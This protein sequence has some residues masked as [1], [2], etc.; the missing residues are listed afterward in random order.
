MG[1]LFRHT[2]KIYR[3]I[4]IVI[5]IIIVVVVVRRRR[6]RH[7]HRH[8]HPDPH[9]HH[10]PSSLAFGV[11]PIL[12]HVSKPSHPPRKYIEPIFHVLPV[13]KPESGL[14]LSV[15]ILCQGC[16]QHPKNNML[17]LQTLDKIGGYTPNSDLKTREKP[18]WEKPWCLPW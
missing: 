11:Y 2:L 16:F 12:R 10:H 7:R 15:W 13:A 6:R 18:W 3:W 17:L 9:H 8:P 1:P 4:V 14:W 5:I